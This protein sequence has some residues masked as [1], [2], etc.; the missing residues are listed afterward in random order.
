[1]SQQSAPK[2]DAQFFDSLVLYR[3]RAR[4]QYHEDVKRQRTKLSLWIVKPY[5]RALLEAA[6][7]FFGP[8]ALGGMRSGVIAPT[9]ERCAFAAWRKADWTLGDLQALGC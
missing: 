9:G 2:G 3:S 5:G 8:T 1:M 6:A 4:Y 7:V